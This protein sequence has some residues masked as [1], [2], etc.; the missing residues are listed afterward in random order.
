MDWAP[1]SPPNKLMIAM[2]TLC[3]VSSRPRLALFF[4]LFLS[5]IT[6]VSTVSS[7]AISANSK[8]RGK[9][10]LRRVKSSDCNDGRAVL[11]LEM[12]VAIS[13]LLKFMPV[14]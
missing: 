12:L 6:A 3:P 13:M 2:L 4:L 7:R 14:R 9:M 5:M 8:A 1:G 11:M 10:V